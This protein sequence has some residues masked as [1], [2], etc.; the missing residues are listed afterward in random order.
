MLLGISEGIA[1]HRAKWLEAMPQQDNKF[2][3]FMAYTALA[4]HTE[5]SE[6]RIIIAHNPRCC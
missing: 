2:L 4:R 6:S 3:T 1:P 5:Y